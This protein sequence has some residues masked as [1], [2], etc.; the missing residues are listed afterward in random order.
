VI[1]KNKVKE[2]DEIQSVDQEDKYQFPFLVYT[3]K[4]NGQEI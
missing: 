4:S 2:D 3:T 1:Q